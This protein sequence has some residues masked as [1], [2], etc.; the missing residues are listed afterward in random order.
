MS[1]NEQ[2]IEVYQYNLNIIAITMKI[3]FPCKMHIQ[4]NNNT[5]TTEVTPS[6]A[7]KFVFNQEVTLQEDP[8]KQHF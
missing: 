1:N 7:N 2:E 3:K 8:D 4:F 5:I 6:T